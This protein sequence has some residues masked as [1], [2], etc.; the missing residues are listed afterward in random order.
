VSFNRSEISLVVMAGGLGSRFGGNKQLVSVGPKGEAFLDYAIRDAAELGLG[1]VIIVARTDLNNELHEHLNRQHL[2]DP[3][4]VVVHQ[5]A[6]G[7]SRAKPWG[8]G[9][10]IL[11]ASPEVHG[12][13]IVV[14]ADDHY[15]MSGIRLAVEAL[16]ETDGESAV[17]VAFELKQT[18]SDTGSVTRGVC[19]LSEVDGSLVE[20]VETHG[21][22]R[23]EVGILADD[24]SGRLEEEVPVSMNL[25]A[26]PREAVGRL[27]GQWASFYSQNSD[28][29]SSEFL[30]PEALDHQRAEGLLSIKVVKST[31][32]WIGIT[33]R[34]DLVIAQNLFRGE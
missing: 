15:G 4:I 10:A 24:P 8:T 14:N 1:Q 6:F 22:R 29:P 21:I 20:L 18:L 17:L 19:R 12:P 2:K 27:A 32:K 9:H 7:P 16:E 13:I 25:W 5:D 31:E 3:S 33:N 30:L 26:L 28:D 23:D 34:D 11:S